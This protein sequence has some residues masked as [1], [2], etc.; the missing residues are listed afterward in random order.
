MV[1]FVLHMR[2][3]GFFCERLDTTII[4]F[5]FLVMHFYHMID[6]VHSTMKSQ[7]TIITHMMAFNA[8]FVQIHI[9]D[10]SQGAFLT[11]DIWQSIR[12]P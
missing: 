5:Q 6:D 9:I 12:M 1:M 7:L 4:A 8:M 2:N 10:E 11:T 3:K